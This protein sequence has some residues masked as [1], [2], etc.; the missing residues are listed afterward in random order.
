MAVTLTVDALR[1][2]LRLGDT[3]EEVAEA[4]RLLAYASEAVTKYA[5]AAP[6]AIQN[7]AAIRVAGFLFDQPLASRGD[8]FANALRSSGA[9]A[10][11]APYRA[12][13][14]GVAAG[15]YGVS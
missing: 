1:D 8:A 10:I 15:T 5:P 4:T 11:L 6:D 3:T 2:A 7:E 12:H 13:K 9:A 14:L